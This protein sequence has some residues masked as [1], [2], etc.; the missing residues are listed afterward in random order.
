M[1]IHYLQHVDF[2]DPANILV[3]ADKK[4]HTVSKT[5]L[6]NHE[7]MPGV[8]DFD[9]LVVMGGP[10]SVNEGDKYPWIND[11]KKLIERAIINNKTV[12]GICL[13]SQLIADVLGAKVYKNKVK[14]IG[15]FPVK[16]TQKSKKNNLFEGFPDE[17]ISFHWHGDTFDLPYGALRIASSDAT[18]NQGFLYKKN[19]LA[20]QFHL[21]SSI[22]SA[23]KLI[24]YCSGELVCGQYIQDAEYILSR[25]DYFREIKANLQIIL[26]RLEKQK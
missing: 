12:I 21:E 20:L 8:D 25:E 15:W 18:L 10:M 24:K 22:E 19:V 26:D 7:P 17:F 23:G 5:E 13:G 16:L 14:E 9:W 6:F 2:E 3:W 1:K 4:Q 11:E